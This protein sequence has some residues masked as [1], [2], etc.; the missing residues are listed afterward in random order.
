MKAQ[1]LT[2]TVNAKLDVDRKTADV[3]LRLVEIYLNSHRE[4]VLRVKNADDGGLELSFCE[5]ARP[6]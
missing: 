6:C 2:V 5:L 1:E 3:C 4:T